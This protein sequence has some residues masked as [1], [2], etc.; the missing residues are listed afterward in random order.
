VDSA[1]QFAQL[2]RGFAQL[3]KRGV[4]Q[5]DRVVRVVLDLVSEQPQVD[6]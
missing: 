1:R 4:E 5:L 6:A 3:L 2:A